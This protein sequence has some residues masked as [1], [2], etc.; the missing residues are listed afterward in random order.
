MKF[1]IIISIFLTAYVFFCGVLV[2]D[3]GLFETCPGQNR[4]ED[5]GNQIRPVALLASETTLEAGDLP[6]ESELEANDTQSWGSDT[7]DRFSS[8]QAVG[9]RPRTVTLGSVDPAS[10]YKFQVEL[11]S[12]GAAIRTATLSEYNDRQPGKGRFVLLA[13][14]SR[15]DGS[16]ILSIAN[17]DF[18][19]TDEGLKLRLD[20]LDWACSEIEEEDGSQSVSFEAVIRDAGGRDAVKLTKSYTVMRDSYHL[21]CEMEVENLTADELKMQYEL[22]GPLGIKREGAR[23]DA[24]KIVGGFAGA[25]GRT[26]GVTKEIVT[27]FTGKLRNRLG[28]RDAT[29]EYEAAQMAYQRAQT[30]PQKAQA[31][32][33][34]LAALQQLR[35]RHERSDVSFLW[36]ATVNKYFTAILRPV[37]QAGSLTVDWVVDKVARY[38]D[39]DETKEG[40]E[41]VGFSYTIDGGRLEAGSIERYKFQL[42]LGPKDKNLFEKNE[43]YRKLGYFH[44]ITFLSCCCP[45]SMVNP[46]AFGM[47]AVMKWMYGIIPNYGIVIIIFVFVVRLV[48]HP[49]TKSSQVSMMKMQKLSPQVEQI[50][51]QYEHNK[52]EMNRRVMA[53]YKEQG[54]TPIMGCLPMFLQMPIWIAL[55]SAIYA[56][57]D[58]RGA[59]FLPVWITDLSVP[60]ALFKFSPINLPL[61]GKLESFNLL[62][63]LLAVGMYLQQKLMPHPSSA[64]STANPQAAQQQ[65]M[66]LIMMP[67][68]MLLFLYNAP[69]GLNLYIMASTFAGILEQYRIR[70]HREELEEKEA[71]SLVEVTA[72]T[73]GKAKKKKPKPFYKI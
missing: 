54:A 9:G 65:K 10:G 12:K 63:I 27:P 49:V 11:S 67:I 28:L 26:S 32:Q 37:P 3:S 57:I 30:E 33:R 29:K 45:A 62:P 39:R 46:L 22:Q 6:G 17:S 50:K 48:L 61:L 38:Y 5:V 55:Y 1:K 25:D 53:L 43:L 34:E 4:G 51:K 71:Q 40:D 52:A 13:P 19:F 31:K 23:I 42:Y 2:L 21:E 24:R 68:M 70:R 14:V 64:Q 73:G 66:M 47:L 7:E 36:A 18:V 20:R 58:L 60:D 41:T 59:P 72:K 35:I 69:S 8:L 16:E 56:S 15:R 44:T